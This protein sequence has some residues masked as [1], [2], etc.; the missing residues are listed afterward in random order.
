[1]AGS[2]KTLDFDLNDLLDVNTGTP[3]S[4][5]TSKALVWDNTTGTFIFTTSALGAAA[6]I[7]LP[8]SVAN[9]GTGSANAADARTALGLVI[10]TNVQAYDAEL[11]ALAGL[12]SAA[13]QFPYFTGSGT[14][15]TATITSAARGVLDDTTTAAMLVSLGA[16]GRLLAKTVYTTGTTATHN[17]NSA[18]TSAL[19]VMV[20]GG[21]GGGG[22]SGAAAQ[23]ASA[24]AGGAGGY[25]TKYL[26]LGGITSAT[27]TVGAK[28]TGGT[29]GANN[30]NNGTASTWTHNA[31][32]YSAGLG[33]GG[34][35]MA[36]G[37]SVTSAAG[38]AGGSTTNGDSDSIGGAAGMPGGRLSGT[39][40]IASHGG[41]S[42]WGGGGVGGANAAGGAATPY[43]AGGGGAST[44]GNTNRAGGDGAGGVIVVW[45][46]S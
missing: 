22:V 34:T 19:I 12:T 39:Q 13:D 7:S 16:T 30:G 42:F 35:A 26:S 43:C 36:A 4:G 29:A 9:G 8:V 24:G 40:V 44:I 21:G 33:S 20:G 1:M 17:Y 46:Y 32:V 18:A 3:G 23:S 37:T 41:G 45:E 31:T 28:G 15:S 38:G 27:Y 6:Y 10:G 25:T 14:A 5:D 2:T 11:A